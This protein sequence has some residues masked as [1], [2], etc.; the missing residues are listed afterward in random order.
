MKNDQLFDAIIIGGSFAGLSAALALGR[1]NRNIL[2]IDDNNP[3]NIQAPRAHNFLTWDNSKPCDII[4]KAKADVKKYDTVKFIGGRADGA[5][6]ISKGFEVVLANGERYETKK[7]LFATG[8]KDV[9]PDIPGL[10][11]SWGISVLHCPYCHGYE[12]KDKQTAVLGNGINAFDVCMVLTQW[13]RDIR[14]LTNGRSELSDEQRIRLKKHNIEIIE[15]EI[16]RIDHEGGQVKS[17]YFKDKT[18]LSI[19][20]IY[21]KL[22]HTQHSDIPEKLGCKIKDDGYIEVDECKKTSMYGVYAAGDNTSKGRTISFAVAA[23]T[24]AG[25]MINGELSSES[26]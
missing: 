14:L 21:A 11:A 16:D 3:C 8:V 12:V 22:G 13:T 1:A 2:V 15:N 5:K 23:G 24:V 19:P 7:L 18:K 10:S 20:V 17:L 25:M 9:I 26:F 4:A 6:Q